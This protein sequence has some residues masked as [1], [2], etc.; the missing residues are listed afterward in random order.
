MNQASQ[1]TLPS[2]AELES[3]I[4]RREVADVVMSRLGVPTLSAALPYKEVQVE[5]RSGLCFSQKSFLDT[6]NTRPQVATPFVQPAANRS[7]RQ[8]SHPITVQAKPVDLGSQ[9][10]GPWSKEEDEVL[11][12]LV[13]ESN[14]LGLRRTWAKIAESM[15]WRTGKQCRDRWMTYLSPSIKK[16]KDCPW[17]DEEDELILEGWKK[18]GGCWSKISRM[19]TGRPPPHI[20]N[21]FYGNLKHLVLDSLPSSR[22]QSGTDGPEDSP[23]LTPVLLTTDRVRAVP[24]SL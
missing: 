12:G 16:L 15:P 6:R 7:P 4:R 13:E 10:K 14:Q 20:K 8:F 22:R 24:Q 11:L 9:I 5:T 17:T 18:W 23:D 21:R 1:R 19:L 3:E 2:F